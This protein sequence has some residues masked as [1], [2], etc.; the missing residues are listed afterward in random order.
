MV[1]PDFFTMFWPDMKGKRTHNG[2]SEI[3]EELL[4]THCRFLGAEKLND[5]G[6]FLVQVVSVSSSFLALL[7]CKVSLSHYFS[8]N[9]HFLSLLC[10]NLDYT[11]NLVS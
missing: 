10:S 11:T 7:N 6:P 1:K 5:I 2:M 4:N 9:I 3:Q 8:S